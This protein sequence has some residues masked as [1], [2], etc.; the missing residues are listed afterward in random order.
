[1]SVTQMAP[2]NGHRRLQDRVPLDD[3]MADARQARPG[4]ALQ[5]LIG[6]LIFGI[7]FVIAQVCRVIF[8]SGA[9][10]ASAA[11]MGWRQANHQPLNVPSI[12]QLL[13]E[14]QNLRAE[15]SRLQV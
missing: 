5:G 6:G 13:A 11:K 2:P 15:L 14:N 8:F 9:W 7:V 1:M 3:I 10:C 12:E 4:R